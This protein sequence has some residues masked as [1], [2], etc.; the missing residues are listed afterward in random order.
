MSRFM[1]N[2]PGPHRRDIKRLC[3]EADRLGLD[4]HKNYTSTG[5]VYVL[6]YSAMDE[7]V[8][9]FGSHAECY[10]LHD[11]SILSG[12]GTRSSAPLPPGFDGYT[13]QAVQ[14]LRAWAGARQAAADWLEYSTAVF[15]E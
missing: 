10:N 13:R 7:R 9:R 11:Y 12:G 14:D 3:A 6:V 15:G 2:Q 1:L 8:Y 5:T 4:C